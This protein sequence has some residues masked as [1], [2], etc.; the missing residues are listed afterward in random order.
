MLSQ[1]IFIGKDV[2]FLGW[3]QSGREEKNHLLKPQPELWAN[4]RK[5][6]NPASEGWNRVSAY[7]SE[8]A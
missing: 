1:N 6:T 8:R 3:N 5:K 7:G 2:M 4:S